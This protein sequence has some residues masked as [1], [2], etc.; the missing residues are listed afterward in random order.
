RRLPEP[1]SGGAPL[2]LARVLDPRLVLGGQ[3]QR[4]PDPG[5]LERTL[6]VGVVRDL[7]LDHLLDRARVAPRLAGALPDGR[8][9][10][11]D[12]ELTG[13]AAGADEAVAGLPGA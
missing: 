8:Q 6:P 5:V 11:L 13:L 3:R 4:R 10:R 7:H 1:Q 2:Q 9:E 12:V